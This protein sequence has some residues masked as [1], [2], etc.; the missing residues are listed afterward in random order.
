MVK[1]EYI[2]EIQA[3]LLEDLNSE[4]DLCP[5]GMLAITLISGQYQGKVHQ[6]TID[7]VMD[8]SRWILTYL[9]HCR[10]MTRPVDRALVTN[11][12]KSLEYCI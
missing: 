2:A 1:K 3:L 4:D 6:C 5:N 8:K 12:I 11:L 10:H 9:M 7:A